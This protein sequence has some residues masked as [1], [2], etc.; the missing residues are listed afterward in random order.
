[1]KLHLPNLRDAM[2]RR[3]V[4]AA[5]L[6]RALDWSEAKAS[7]LLNGKTKDVTVAMVKE[8]EAY[9]GVSAA[10]LLDLEDAAQT[11]A[12][13]LLLKRYRAAQDRDRKVA[14]AALSPRQP[15]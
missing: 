9:L 7:R 8:L 10:Y 13:R 11:E 1:M 4:T 6:A 14:E 3:Q 2:D 15:D 12:E 5:D